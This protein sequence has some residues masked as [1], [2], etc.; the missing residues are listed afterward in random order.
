MPSIP[1]APLFFRTRFSAA[2]RFVPSRT[3]SIRPVRRST[4][5][6]EP[7]LSEVA[8]LVCPLRRDTP[9]PGD[10]HRRSTAGFTQDPFGHRSFAI[11]GSLAPVTRASYPISVRQLMGYDSCFL[12]TVAQPSA[13][14]LHFRPSGQLRGGLAPPGVCPCRAHRRT[15]HLP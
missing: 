13:L 12:Q 2:R 6:P 11:L 1:G 14:A 4:S 9:S 7:I 5:P 8:D 3:A 10:R 15:P